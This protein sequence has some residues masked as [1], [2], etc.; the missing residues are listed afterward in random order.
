ML[1][2]VIQETNLY[3]RVCYSCNRVF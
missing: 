3:Q 2:V 1:Y